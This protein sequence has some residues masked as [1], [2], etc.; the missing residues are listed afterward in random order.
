MEPAKMQIFTETNAMPA[1][2]RKD[3]RMNIQMPI[4]MTGI[5]PQTLEQFE[6]KGVTENVS[7]Y[8]AC[9]EIRRGLVRVGSI[10]GL[11][12]GS[13]FDA[14]CRVV[15]TK[16]GGNGSDLVGVELISITGQWVISN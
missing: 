14:Q 8:G 3:Y 16:D 9:F 7:R 5:N 1:E 11:S 10:I 4:T 2:R 15:W 13:K 6:T 12:Q